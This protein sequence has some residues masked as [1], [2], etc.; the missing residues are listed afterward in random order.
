MPQ[1]TCSPRGHHHIRDSVIVKQCFG[2]VRCPFLSLPWSSSP[3]LRVAAF[4]PGYPSVLREE[5][6]QFLSLCP[7]VVA[8]TGL[9]H[10]CSSASNYS[11]RRTFLWR[12]CKLPG[13][14]A[15][16]RGSLVH[17]GHPEPSLVSLSLEKTQ[18]ARRKLR[19][20]R[21]A[22]LPGKGEAQG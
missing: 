2:H 15:A 6:T 18:S 17:S 8:A 13:A 7:R 20:G 22:T 10:Y 21:S 4:H 3:F 19:I 12:N 5:E 14:R 11:Q 1:F 9:C 16:D